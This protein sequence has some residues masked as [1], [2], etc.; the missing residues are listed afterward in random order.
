MKIWLSQ[1]HRETG[2]RNVVLDM[3]VDEERACFQVLRREVIGYRGRAPKRKLRRDGNVRYRF[4]RQYLERVMATFPYAEL[5]PGLDRRLLRAA[6]RAHPPEDVPEMDI[7]DLHT[8]LY[9]FQK[10]GVQR[11]LEAL[12]EQGWHFL[13][14]GLGLGK[15]VQ[16]LA[17][18]IL[19]MWTPCLIVCTNNGKFMPWERRLSE[20]TDIDDVVVLDA[21]TQN[22]EQRNELIAEQHEVTIVNAEA[23]RAS[24]EFTGLQG[25]YNVIADHPALFENIWEFLITDE[26]H[27]FKSHRA[28]QTIGW[29]E[30]EAN[31]ELEISGT[32]ILNRIEEVWTALH[33]T[34]PDRYPDYWMFERDITIK[35]D[36]IVYTV[37][38]PDTGRMVEKRIPPKVVGYK[39]DRFI[40]LRDYIQQRNVS[41]RRRKEQVLDD[42]PEVTY[43][44]ILVD[45]T[46]EQRALY[47]RIVED[48]ELQLDSGEIRDVRGILAVVGYA[49]QA[50]WSPELYGGS[51]TSA[52]L[53]ELR[54]VVG[55]GIDNLQKIIIGSQWAKATRIM[56]REFEDHGVAYVEGRVKG[57]KRMAEID[58]FNSDEDTWLYI[59]TIQ[60]NQ[61]AI[62]LN[63]SYVVLT[64]RMWSPLRNEQFIGR[65]AAGGLRGV[66][67]EHVTVISILA[68]DTIDE[69][70]E[71]LLGEKHR[72]FNALIERDAGEP[73]QQIAVGEIA[74]LF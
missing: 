57:R 4:G 45:L 41:T 8:E 13:N 39:P 43:T 42:L 60:A 18:L 27:I 10:I 59:G 54:N 19:R 53:T 24:K 55:Q 65:S 28:K 63:A 21:N 69:R 47:N 46:T 51:S 31:H 37:R 61:E 38:D 34:N 23:C 11:C 20:W 16:A 58:R 68:R 74:E 6:E 70:I 67:A 1:P 49:K 35:S 22:R 30:I 66:G 26:H 64:D 36:P 9:D 14:D 44:T 48:M 15:T 73:R 7:P 71:Q 52:K 32:P 29:Q 50:C 33:R 3:T 2:K 72:T 25:E 62:D 40:E 56:R 12:D 17:C 5:S